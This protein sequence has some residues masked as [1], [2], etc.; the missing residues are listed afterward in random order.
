MYAGDMNWYGLDLYFWAHNFNGNLFL[1]FPS[2]LFPS[3]L[4]I[5]TKFSIFYRIFLSPIL[6]FSLFIFSASHWVFLFSCF[7]VESFSM[8]FYS[9]SAFLL[10]S[11]NSWALNSENYYCKMTIQTHRT[12]KFYLFPAKFHQK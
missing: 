2:N 5:A 3:L 8:D 11:V 1:H 9:H 12:H 10:S 7:H 4:F 6:N